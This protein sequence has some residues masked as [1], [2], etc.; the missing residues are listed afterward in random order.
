MNHDVKVYIPASFPDEV[1][2]Q[3]TASGAQYVD[4]KG[5]REILPGLYST[6]EMGSGLIEQSVFFSPE[7]GAGILTGCAH[8]GIENIVEKVHSFTGKKVGVVIGGFHLMSASGSRLES[9]VETFEK[10]GVTRLLPTHCTGDPARSYFKKHYGEKF[11]RKGLSE[12]IVL[13]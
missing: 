2:K 6:G 9:I 8:P 5:K 13:K 12:T 4:V 7:R 10:T 3:I 1:R 11:I